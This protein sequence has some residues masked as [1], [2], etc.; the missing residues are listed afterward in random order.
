MEINKYAPVT[1]LIEYLILQQA[2]ANKWAH[3][4][5]V[6]PSIKLVY[7]EPSDCQALGFSYTLPFYNITAVFFGYTP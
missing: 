3:I 4:R 2:L 7:I 6:T 5:S 1:I